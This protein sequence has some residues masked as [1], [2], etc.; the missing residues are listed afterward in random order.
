MKGRIGMEVD[1]SRS[2]RTA[3]AWVS[4]PRAGYRWATNRSTAVQ[5]SVSVVGLVFG[6]PAALLEPAVLLLGVKP[7]LHGGPGRL[8]RPPGGRRRRHRVRQQYG[9]LRGRRAPVVQLSPVRG[10][11]HH[12]RAVDQPALT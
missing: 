1:W 8:G 11:G 5:P 7:A 9:Q 6:G 10:R 12:Q 2:G 4:D 3:G